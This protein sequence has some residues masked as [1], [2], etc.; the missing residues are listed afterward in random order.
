MTGPGSWFAKE[1][2][3][4]ATFSLEQDSVFD[5]LGSCG[6]DLKNRILM[7]QEIQENPYL[8]TCFS[9]PNMLLFSRHPFS[10]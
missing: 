4:L 7:H 3:L 10:K 1:G 8:S 6:Q 5:L 2:L 9:F